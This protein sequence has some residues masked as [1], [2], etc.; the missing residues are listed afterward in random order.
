MNNYE[1]ALHQAYKDLA[2]LE[3]RRSQLMQLIAE[4]EAA[5]IASPCPLESLPPEY[6]AKGITEEIRSILISSP[7]HLSAVQIRDAL[8][9]RRVTTKN[10]RTLLISVHT[11][12]KRIETEVHIERR[13]NKPVFKIVQ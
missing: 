1:R 10:V 8:L 13:D 6:V 11:I 2:A 5:V 3:H 7:I 12:L 4:L 9:A